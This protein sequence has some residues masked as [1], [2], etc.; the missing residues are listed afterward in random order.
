MVLVGVALILGSLAAGLGPVAL[1]GGVLL[2]W[3]GIVKAIAL[4]IWRATL[5]PHVSPDHVRP[6]A[7][8]K[9]TFR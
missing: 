9:T 2:L 3:S 7:R 8:P 4:R 6:D 5:T 1:V